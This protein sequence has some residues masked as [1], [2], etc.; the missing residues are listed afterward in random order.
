MEYTIN[1]LLDLLYE[2]VNTIRDTFIGFFGEEYVDMQESMGIILFRKNFSNILER[3]FLLH[4]LPLDDKYDISDKVL[5]RLH[6]RIASYRCFIYVWWPTVTVSNENN[7][8]VTIQDLYAKIEVRMDGRIPYENRG[9]Q[10]NR[11]TYNKDQFISNFLH[12]HVNGIP[13]DDFT[14]F[15]SP[16][17]GTGPINNTI[18]SLKSDYDETYW[19]L[20]CQELSMYVTVES[21]TGG[22]YYKLEYIRNSSRSPIA[23]NGFDRAYNALHLFTNIGFTNEELKNFIKYYLKHGHLSFIFMENR[24]QCGLSKYEYIVDISNVFIDFYNN[25]LCE[26]QHLLTQCFENELLQEVQVVYGNFY[27][28]HRSNVSTLSLD[29]YRDKLVLTF[30]GKE[31]KT[32]IIEEEEPETTLTN[33]LNPQFAMRVLQNILNIINFRFKNGENKSNDITSTCERVCY[34]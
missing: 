8:S 26:G 17:L 11:A 29:G 27:K 7:K 28:D 23:L 30:K 33:I 34:I 32:S 10:L 31:I 5:A 2:K 9:F 13:K 25:F 18:L 3:E 15:M 20:F 16:C 21:L 22:P 6:E 19:M 12:S 14:R 1:Q 4:L 24:F